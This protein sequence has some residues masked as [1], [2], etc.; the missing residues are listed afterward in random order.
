[1]FS[2]S[3][4][5]DTIYCTIPVTRQ[6]INT[7]SVIKRR[8]LIHKQLLVIVQDKRC[9]YAVCQY[10]EKRSVCYIYFLNTRQNLNISFNR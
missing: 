3:S 10:I 6:S 9:I 1:M 2:I 5:I 4:C 8:L 7:A